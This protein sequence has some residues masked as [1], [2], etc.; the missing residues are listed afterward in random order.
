MNNDFI[1]IFEVTYFSNGELLISLLFLFIGII[2]LIATRRGYIGSNNKIPRKSL[3]YIITIIFT[4]VGLYMTTNDLK[5][6]Y[7]LKQLLNNGKCE[8]VQGHVKV[9]HKEKKSGHDIKGGDHIIIN[10]KHFHL[11]Y[12]IKTL[13][14]KNTI[15]NGGVLKEGVYVRLHYVNGEILKVEIK[16]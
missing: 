3:A 5:D 16:E 15:E 8:I 1:K 14:Y 12:F 7:K 2:G 6:G 10:N 11:S 9:L 13:A 4:I